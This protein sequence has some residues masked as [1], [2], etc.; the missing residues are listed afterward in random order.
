MWAEHGMSWAKLRAPALYFCGSRFY[1]SWPC[2]I[3]NSVVHMINLCVINLAISNLVRW[4]GSF[5]NETAAFQLT[6]VPS[7]GHMIWKSEV[8][9][10]MLL[11]DWDAKM[12]S[13]LCL[14]QWSA[15]SVSINW[16]IN[17]K[18][19]FRETKN[20][21]KSQNKTPRILRFILGD[22]AFCFCAPDPDRNPPFGKRCTRQKWG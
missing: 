2:P 14:R 16:I 7:P 15:F 12:R 20:T 10:S 9:R 19:Q 11:C 5:V 1:F 21:R 18:V 17:S 4:L 22:P 6:L 3:L 13:P 8:L